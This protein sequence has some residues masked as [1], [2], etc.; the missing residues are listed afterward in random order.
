M[1]EKRLELFTGIVSLMARCIVNRRLYYSDHPSIQSYS[2]IFFKKVDILCRELGKDELFIGVFENNFIF[3]GKRVFGVALSGRAVVDFAVTLH[4]G[5]FRIYRNLRRDEFRR[6]LDITALVDFKPADINESRTMLKEQGITNIYPGAVF[7][8]EFTGDS[9]GQDAWHGEDGRPG[10]SFAGALALKQ[11]MHDAVVEAIGDAGLGRQLDTHRTRSVA[12]FMLKHMRSSFMDILHTVYYPTFENYTVSHSIRVAALAVYAAS[13]MGW[14]DKDLLAIGVAAML[15][16]IGKCIIPDD[17]LMK[18]G[19]LT[20]VEFEIIRDHP[21]AGAKILS[22]QKELMPFALA[23]C[24][25]HHIRFDGGG[26]P[27]QEKWAVRHPITSLL[28]ICDVFEALTAVRPYKEPMTPEK[29]FTIMVKDKGGFHPEL[30]ASFISLVGFYPP[31]TQVKLSDNRYAI[32]L[33]TNQNLARPML[34]III[35]KSGKL[36]G[37]QDQY[38][39]DMMTPANRNLEINQLILS[40]EDIL[41]AI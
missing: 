6:F 38:L 35:E 1:D 14:D 30:L 22:Q 24:W 13:Q 26:Y 39:V 3:N 29:A 18:R 4:C 23:A 31:G 40:E 36:L 2:D 28:Q 5:G 11:R 37:E 33:K 41:E 27:S 25:G 16:D 32:V 9:D 8:N 34:R 19:R 12:E 10:G 20:R 15:H 7:E 21:R 17:I